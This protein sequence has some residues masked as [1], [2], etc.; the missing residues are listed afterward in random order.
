MTPE[1]DGIY[2]TLNVS[3]GEKYTVSEV[4]IIGE[5]IG[6]EEYLKA[7]L[8]LR[9]DILYNQAQVTY[10]EEFVSKFLGRFGYAYPNVTTIPEINDDDNTVKLT[11]SVDPG[12]RIYVR[13]INFDGNIVTADEG[14]ASKR[15]ANGRR[16]AF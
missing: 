15:Y 9:K 8:P 4:D 13:R 11:V 12:K 3:E 10:A 5:L 7:F 14:I 2:I 16:M 6:Q 1:K